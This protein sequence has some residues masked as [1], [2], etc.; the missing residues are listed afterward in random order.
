MRIGSYLRA[1]GADIS[2]AVNGPTLSDAAS[3]NA[4]TCTNAARQTA[5]NAGAARCWP[6]S[7]KAG[8][9]YPPMVTK[10]FIATL[11]TALVAIGVA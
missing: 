11:I 9:V 7:P 3:T 8:E 5:D 4:V 6:S 1:V 2:L 10:I